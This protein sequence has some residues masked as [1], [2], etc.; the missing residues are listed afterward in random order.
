[1]LFDPYADNRTMGSFILIDETT[2]E[3]LGAGMISGPAGHG[4]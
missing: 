1:M 2:N 4:G 3:T